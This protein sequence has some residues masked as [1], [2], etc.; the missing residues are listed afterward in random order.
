MCTGSPR[1]LFIL[2]SVR[3]GKKIIV[4][5]TYVYSCKL[6]ILSERVP[7]ESSCLYYLVPRPTCVYHHHRREIVIYRTILIDVLMTLAANNESQ[8]KASLSL[9]YNIFVECDSLVH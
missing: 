9:I 8:I 7:A 3:D 1:Y 5:S 6:C 4:F 2:C